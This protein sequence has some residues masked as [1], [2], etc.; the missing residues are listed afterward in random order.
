M[1][2]KTLMTDFYELTMAQTY[3]MEGKQDE[4]VYFV[5]FFR[6]NPFNGGYTISNG[7][8]SIIDYIKNFHFGEDEIN[9]LKGL[10]KF[11]EEFLEYLKNLKF[12]GDIYAVPD[13]TPVFPN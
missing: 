9:Y 6:K 12:T 10:G 8:D 4:V 3:F 2:N 11:N 5:L 1:E 13:G 7:L